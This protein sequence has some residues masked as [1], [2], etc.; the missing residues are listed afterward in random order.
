MV[1]A[2]ISVILGKENKTYELPLEDQ[3][4]SAEGLLRELLDMVNLGKINEAENKLLENFNPENK[5]EFEDAIL[6]YAYLNELDDHF[7]KRCNYTR[8]EID[9]GVREI[10]RRL[11]MEGL[12]EVFEQVM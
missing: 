2:L 10:A 9:T 4:Q 8:E 5:E 6:F 7:L 1:A 12:M 11:G 3:Y